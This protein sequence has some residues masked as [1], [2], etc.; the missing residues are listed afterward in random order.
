MGRTLMAAKYSDGPRGATVR[1]RDP[2]AYRLARPV[3]REL[4]RPTWSGAGPGAGVGVVVLSGVQGAED[5]RRRDV[6]SL[7]FLAVDRGAQ[8]GRPAARLLGELAARAAVASPALRA[9]GAARSAATARQA[10]GLAARDPHRRVAFSARSSTASR[11][12]P[13]IPEAVPAPACPRSHPACFPPRPAGPISGLGFGVLAWSF[14]SV[15]DASSCGPRIVA[16]T[17]LAVTSHGR[18]RATIRDGHRHFTTPRVGRPGWRPDRR[19]NHEVESPPVVT[20]RDV[21]RRGSR[22]RDRA[23]D[24]GRRL[25]AEVNGHRR[26]QRLRA[27][28][29]GKGD[30]QL[31]ELPEWG[32][33]EPF[34]QVEL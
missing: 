10:R 27:R 5:V 28:P 18:L 2:P 1:R 6:G 25:L 16:R 32:R 23:A 29:V 31:D 9:S 21:G 3:T 26:C 22:D 12:D 14:G 30:R 13:R 11:I 15:I 8:V 34:A 7:S 24:P 33:T 20:P 19:A 17:R 4:T